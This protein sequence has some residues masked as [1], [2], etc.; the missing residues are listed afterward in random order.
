MALLLGLSVIEVSSLYAAEKQD[1]TRTAKEVQAC[2]SNQNENSLEI[3]REFD[4]TGHDSY[5]RYYIDGK[6]RGKNGVYGTITGVKAGLDNTKFTVNYSDF[7]NYVAT[8]EIQKIQ[9][10]GWNMR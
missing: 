7:Y 3:Y 5:F 10:N 8:G 2:K 6:T 4:Y 1:R 9:I